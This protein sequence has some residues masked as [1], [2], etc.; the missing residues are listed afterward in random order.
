MMD[1]DALLLKIGQL[2]SRWMD[3]YAEIMPDIASARRRQYSRTS[4]LL[5]S[6]MLRSVLLILPLLPASKPSKYIF[7]GLRHRG[8]IEALPASEVMV[9]GGRGEFLYCL[10][11]GYRFHWIGYIAKSFQLYIWAGK[12]EPFSNALIFI[13]KLFLA[14]AGE[15]R[16]LFLWEDS[17]PT[18]L[19]LSTALASIPGLNVVCIAHGMFPHYKGKGI[20]PEGEHCKFNLVWD[21]SQKKLF[22]GGDD[23]ATFVLGL[24]YEVKPPRSISR[25]VMLV[26]HCGRSSDMAEYFFSLYHFSKI[27]TILQ[28]AGFAVTFRPHPQ[29]DINFI[30]SVFSSVCVENKHKLFASGRMVFIGFVSSLLYEARQFGNIVIALDSSEFP[31]ELDF[32]V[33]GVALASGYKELPLYLSNILDARSTL[34]DARVES[35]SSRFHSSITQIDKFNADGGSGG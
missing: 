23:P 18:G 29:D 34:I 4:L 35:L 22:K 12:K 9:L 11:R 7:Q 24:P 13:Q 20:P 15:K 3:I 8:L 32:D 30:R 16:Y 26:G 6:L 5:H 14:Q 27:F 31:Y 2:N 1:I 28:R 19:T 10:K 17:L 33:D 25:N 21:T